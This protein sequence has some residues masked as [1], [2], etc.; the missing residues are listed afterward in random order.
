[1]ADSEF[2]RRPRTPLISENSNILLGLAHDDSDTALYPAIIHMQTCQR[3]TLGLVSSAT[4]SDQK[5]LL[6]CML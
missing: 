5:S 2:G 1:M 6:V 3:K 4:C